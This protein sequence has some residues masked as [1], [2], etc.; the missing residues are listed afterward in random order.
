[1]T[2]LVL[3]R[4]GH[5]DGIQP[6]RFRGRAELALT[7]L[8]QRQAQAT[9]DRIAAV[10]QPTAVYCSPMERCVRTAGAIAQPFGLYI[11]RVPGLNDFDYGLW[12]GLT[13]ADVR[14][15]WPAEYALW[16]G[17]PEQLTV[18]GGESL[19][20][21]AARAIRGLHEILQRHQAETV[22]IVAHDSVNRILLMHMLDLPMS[23]YRT[24]E[25]APCAINLI[26]FEHGRFVVRLLNDHSHCP[27]A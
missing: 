3:T 7:P 24:L 14:T 9:S 27:L 8:G 2:T 23:H 4:H 15:R 22:V 21:V 5:V 20:D 25:Q 18:P 13:V 19:Y 12:Q 16:C 26:E 1:M 17:G 6:E 10:W 11:E